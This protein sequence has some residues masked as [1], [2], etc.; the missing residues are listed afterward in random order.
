MQAPE[1]E[2]HQNHSGFDDGRMAAE[3][4]ACEQEHD[5]TDNGNNGHELEIGSVAA[6]QTVER[7]AKEHEVKVS[8][9]DQGAERK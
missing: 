6:T 1:I 8:G 5:L 7:V 9:N 4:L 2:Q 3:Q